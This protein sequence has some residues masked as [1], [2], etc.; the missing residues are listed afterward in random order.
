MAAALAEVKRQLGGD[1]VILHTRSFERR[2]LLGVRPRRVVEITA[3]ANI[4][5]LPPR[6]QPGNVQSRR[7]TDAAPS[8]KTPGTA[9]PMVALPVNSSLR[10][11]PHA[12][13][14]ASAPASRPAFSG[15]QQAMRDLLAN[16]V[17]AD[18]AAALVERLQRELSPDQLRDRELVR[19]RLADC[20]ASMLPVGGAITAP[21]DG[22][23]AVIALV[24]PTGVGKT[25]TIAKLAAD[26]A[27]RQQQ[28]VGLIT[29]DTYR[30]AAVDQLR[31]YAEI[32][33]VPL[34]VAATADELRAAL[35]RLADC[36]VV[37][38][39]TP[40]RS[41]R[42]AEHLGA[43]Q[44]ALRALPDCEI[45]LVLSAANARSSLDAAIEGFEALGI[46]RVIFTKLD[47]A[48]GCGV[49]LGCLQKARAAL[50]YV[51]TG[52]NVPADIDVG[53]PRALAEIIVGSPSAQPYRK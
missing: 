42:D 48:V 34:E 10:A 41:P 7:G 45:H 5:D 27:L 37:L 50:S 4:S 11:A 15:A 44:R 35:A 26:L 40:G 39:D 17:A 24:G 32:I 51:T 52:Q 14:A 30:I 46:N 8:T 6:L 38:I 28:R 18:V 31:T 29:L 1:A 16:E 25:T 53:T 20:V 23:Q 12:P 21:A 13:E 47:E 49:M 36:A 19:R 2:G 33:D 9:E 3:S 22:R 43:L